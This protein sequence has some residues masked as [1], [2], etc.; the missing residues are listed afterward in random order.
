MP[1]C[2]YKVSGSRRGTVVTCGRD[3]THMCL[4]E[5]IGDP[6]PQTGTE[7]RCPEHIK[8]TDVIEAWT[9]EEWNKEK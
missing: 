1:C 9:L 3:A 7:R 2:D 5:R 8:A 6:G 4:V